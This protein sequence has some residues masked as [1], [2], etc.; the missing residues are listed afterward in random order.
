[1]METSKKLSL[2]DIQRQL[3]HKNATTTDQ[4][5]KGLVNESNAA[6]VIEDMHCL[7]RSS[8]SKQ[9]KNC[10]DPSKK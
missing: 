8:R 4:Y 1:M 7:S 2:I 9:I 5:L 6:N 10:A 3:R